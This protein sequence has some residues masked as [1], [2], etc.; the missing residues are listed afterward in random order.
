V[1]DG[2]GRQQHG[3]ELGIADPGANQGSDVTDRVSHMCGLMRAQDI[4]QGLQGGLGVGQENTTANSDNFLLD[5]L[6]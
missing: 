4:A 3:D 5:C 1:V 6:E 2:L